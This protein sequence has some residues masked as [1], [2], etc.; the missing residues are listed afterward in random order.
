MTSKY[1]YNEYIDWKEYFIGDI[2]FSIKNDASPVY[3]TYLSAVLAVL[4]GA[5]LAFLYT[6]RIEKRKAYHQVI[7]DFSSDLKSIM[8]LCE[9]YWLGDHHDNKERIRLNKMSYLI[10]AKLNETNEY[11]PLM[12]ELLGEKFSDYENLDEKLFEVATGGNF[13]TSKMQ[14]CPETFMEISSLIVKIEHCLR[15]TRSKV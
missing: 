7:I 8:N 14:S 11:R 3:H 4:L 12:E 9:D 10:S 5:L 2:L 13:Q 1:F 6:K 15:E